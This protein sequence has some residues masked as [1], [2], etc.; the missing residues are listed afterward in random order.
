MP[1]QI[2]SKIR[3]IISYQSLTL[4]HAMVTVGLRL[5]KSA[6]VFSLTLLSGQAKFMHCKQKDRLSVTN[7]LAVVSPYPQSCRK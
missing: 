1:S 3:I 2:P 6:R 7:P 5:K 4:P